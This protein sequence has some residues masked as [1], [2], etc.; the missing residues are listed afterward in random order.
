MKLEYQF[1]IFYI[2]ISCRGHVYFYIGVKYLLITTD[3]LTLT[4]GFTDSYIGFFISYVGLIISYML[5]RVNT[6]WWEIDIHGC[7]SLAK[8]AFAPIY[9]CKNNRR[10][11][12]HNA[13]VPGCSFNTTSPVSMVFRHRKVSCEKWQVMIWTSDD[14]NVCVAQHWVKQCCRNSYISVDHGTSPVEYCH[15]GRLTNS[16]V[17]HN[18]C[19]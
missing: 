14:M 12:R 4:L 5:N 11:W 1:P 3:L 9:A 15:S 8:I 18:R 19:C 17:W 16:S 2:R 10:I 7:Y 6:G 13:S